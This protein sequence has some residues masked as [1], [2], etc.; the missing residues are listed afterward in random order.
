MCGG[1][2][3]RT[4][5][6]QPQDDDDD[7]DGDDDDD[8]DDGGGG[9]CGDDDDYVVV[10]V[11][12]V[13]CECDDDHENTIRYRYI[14]LKVFYLRQPFHPNCHI[15]IFSNITKNIVNSKNK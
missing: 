5:P 13:N 10:E 14:N 9:G 4:S 1:V 7:D 2:L 12:M 6:Q 3:C 11:K 8:N 15:Y